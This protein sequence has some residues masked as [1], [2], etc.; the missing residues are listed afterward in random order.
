[1]N[2][3]VRITFSNRFSDAVVAELP[4]AKHLRN[5]SGR[6]WVPFKMSGDTLKPRFEID[7]QSI[8]S[9]LQSGA[10]SDAVDDLRDKA[11]DKLGDII[12]GFGRKKA[13]KDTTKTP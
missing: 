13:P 7:T 9:R 4:V 2:F 10:A 8:I 12:G 1:M 11:K 6:I 5:N 3:D